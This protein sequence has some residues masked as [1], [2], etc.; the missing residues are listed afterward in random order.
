MASPAVATVVDLPGGADLVLYGTREGDLVGWA[1]ATGD[2]D[3]DGVGD[4]AI[5]VPSASPFP[6]SRLRHGAIYVIFGGR[7]FAEQAAS[8]LG[9]IPH[10]I[11]G[12]HGGQMLGANIAAG[13]LDGD[14]RDDLLM[15]SPW[16]TEGDST[17]H[18]GGAAYVLFGRD[19]A[20]FPGMIEIPE[21]ADVVFAS[22]A[23]DIHV[24]EAVAC[25]DWNGDGRADAAMGAMYANGPAGVRP[26]A[27][28]TYLYFGRARKKFKSRI[29]L[30][31]GAD[32]MVQGA[33]RDDTLG[34]S[35]AFTDW[36]GDGL[37]DLLMGAYYGDGPD[38]TRN[39][40]GDAFILLGGTSKGVK[41]KTI[42]LATPG[43]AIPVYSGWT[44]GAF[45]RSA[46]AADVDG[47]SL[48]DFL[49]S[50]YRA[51]GD[52]NDPRALAGAVDVVFGRRDRPTSID[53]AQGA[54]YRVLGAN[55]FD[56]MGRYLA[57]RDLNGD[58]RAEMLLGAPLGDAE[59]ASGMPRLQSGLVGIVSGH[60]RAAGPDSLDL[61][62]AP[63]DHLIR[64]AEAGDE[65]P[66]AIQI[67]DIDA[68]GKMDIVI[69]APSAAGRDNVGSHTG[70]VYFLL[71]ASHSW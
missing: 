20:A 40:T 1:L 34:R 26:H 52:D 60:P 35:L 37:D 46:A 38:N 11:V 33:D 67:L 39:D 22:P 41:K 5:G 30:D 68:D 4:L 62:S 54:E 69:G 29:A 42:D 51:P 23:A 57:A 16:T 8:G 70:E 18:E 43:F 56:S 66:G 36:N 7:D 55:Y 6:E 19:R 61:A 50:A 47:D 10:R 65:I 63:F 28:A 2:F 31:R 53:L 64:G 12:T 15:G 21:S 13:D 49:V 58:G 24:G 17:S 45:G 48:G 44:R 9:S 32:L 27:G 71:G 3:G 25:G 59:E 14:G